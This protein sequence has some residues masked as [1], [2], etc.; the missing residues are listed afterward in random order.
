MAQFFAAYQI[1][2]RVGGSKQRLAPEADGDEV[3]DFAVREARHLLRLGDHWPEVVAFKVADARPADDAAGPDAIVVTADGRVDNAV[4]GHHNRAGEAG[5]F[6]L[7]VLPAAAVVADQMLKFTQFRVAVRRQHFAVG[8]NIHAGAFRLFQQV[9]KIVQIVAG[10]QNAFA[11]HGFDIDLRR[12]RVAIFAGFARVQNTH[13]V[14]VHLT[15]FHRA[16]Q[17]CIHVRRPGAEPRHH[18][19]I[20]TING[21]VILPE[22]MR[23]L[24]IGRRAFQA[25]EAKQA[26][27]ENILANHRFI[28][29]RRERGGLTL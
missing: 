15:D 28:D 20:L 7:L 29:I 23:V 21:V 9:I 25:V 18:L 14:E 27:T 10:N 5:E 24:H 4:G 16:L 17:Q 26:Q 1:D 3:F 19:V 6:N 12:R 11:R 13:D 2:Q 8:V 22:H